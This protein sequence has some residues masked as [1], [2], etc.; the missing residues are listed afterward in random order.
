MAWPAVAVTLV[1]FFLRVQ[2]LDLVPPAFSYGEANRAVEAMDILQGNHALVSETLRGVT[3]LFMYLIAGAFGLLGTRVVAQRLLVACLSTLAIPLTYLF[4]RWLFRSLGERRAGMVG[5]LAALGLATSYWH[6]HFSRIGLE[7]SLIPAAMLLCFIALWRGMTTGRAGYVVLSGAFLGLGL[8]VD[9]V[10]RTVPVLLGLFVIYLW[11]L[12]PLSPPLKGGEM[13]RASLE[14]GDG[15]DSPRSLLKEGEMEKASLKKGDGLDSPLSPLKGGKDLPPLGPP[16]GKRRVWIIGLAF[17]LGVAVVYAP[18]AVYFGGH[19]GE[20]VGRGTEAFF[21]RPAIHHGDPLGAL[22]RGVTGNVLTFGFTGD[23][24]AAA[25]FPGRPILHLS[26]AAAFWGG[27]ALSLYRFRRGPYAFCALWWGTMFLAVVLMPD[28]VPNHARLMVVAPVIYIFPALAIDWI[29]QETRYRT[30]SRSK[31]A[32]VLMV[33]VVALLYGAAAVSAYRDYFGRWAGSEA[34][35]AAFHGPDGELSGRINADGPDSVYLL[36]YDVLWSPQPH[37]VVEF[38]HDG[39]AGYRTIHVNELEVPW[40]LN[41]ATRG[42]RQVKLV[43]MAQ[44][45]QEFL[46]TNA[47]PK[48]LLGFYLEQHGQFVRAESYAGGEIREY[49]LPVDGVNFGLPLQFLGHG[50]AYDRQLWLESSALGNASYPGFEEDG[51]VAAGDTVWLILQW[52][53][54]NPNTDNHVAHVRLVDHDGSVVAE[55]EHLLLDNLH[56]PSSQWT[57]RDILVLDFYLLPVPGDLPPGEYALMA[58]VYSPALEEFLPIHG[59]EGETFFEMRSVEI[60]SGER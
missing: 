3:M 47:D 4:T 13:E 43:R 35:Y 10:F 39:G 31:L 52:D 49:S 55:V 19:P 33:V 32:A 36:P 6:V 22:W 56:Q 45:Q 24:S 57:K 53:I 51:E 11:V 42:K 1:G 58:G 41:E 20:F 25:N 27:M 23:S 38:F 40:Q 7:V 30:R 48:D 37:A 44:G 18:L 28:R 5:V 15:L 2:R 9:P 34:A 21:L 54:L 26:M 29:W 50:V 12:P 17:V 14:E 8:Y 60:V 16:L 59:T 46:A